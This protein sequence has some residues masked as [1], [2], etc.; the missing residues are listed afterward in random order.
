[1]DGSNDLHDGILI[2]IVQPLADWCDIDL[3]Y[4]PMIPYKVS[5]SKT[6]LMKSQQRQFLK[7]LKETERAMFT[8]EKPESGHVTDPVEAKATAKQL[9]ENASLNPD[10]ATV[11]DYDASEVLDNE[12]DIRNYLEAILDETKDLDDDTAASIFLDALGDAA[13]T[14]KRV[15]DIA[16]RA[17]VT[18]ESLHRSLTA[19]ANPSFRTVFSALRELIGNGNTKNLFINPQLA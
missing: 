7:T 4:I 5:I 16:K 15:S 18:R 3:P 1:M 14:E 19:D 8:T 17:N 10:D 13:K 12:T 9:M 11:E 6:T 2:L